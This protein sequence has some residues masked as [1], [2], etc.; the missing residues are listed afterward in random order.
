MEVVSASRASFLS[1]LYRFFS[2]YERLSCP[3]VV[4]VTVVLRRRY[5]SLL[6]VMNEQPEAM[7][8]FTLV[9]GLDGEALGWFEWRLRGIMLWSYGCGH[10]FALKDA[11][12]GLC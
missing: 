3:T 8:M 12:F 4:L 7:I 10:W 6:E 9:D 11:V 2:G 5:F 1:G